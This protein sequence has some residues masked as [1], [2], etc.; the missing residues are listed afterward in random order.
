[1]LGLA[2]RLELLTGEQVGVATNDLRLL[3]HLFL[4]DADSATLLGALEQV[5]LELLLEVR[6]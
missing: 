6:R 2:E 4:A 5:L 1:V 3:R